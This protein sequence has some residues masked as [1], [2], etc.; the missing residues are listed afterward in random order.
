MVTINLDG[1]EVDV[2]A[3]IN[4]IEAAAIHGTEV[5]H[6]CYHPQLSVAGNCR[7]CLV[8][9]GTPMRDRGTGEPILDKDGVQKIG[10]IPKPVIGCGTNVSPGMHVKTNSSMVTGSQRGYHGVPPCE[11]PS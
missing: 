1:K 9:M 6:Y 3:G 10:W 8:E 11:P 7:M 2:P 4:I 5:P